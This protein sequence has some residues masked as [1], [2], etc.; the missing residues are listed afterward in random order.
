GGCLLL[1]D[2]QHRPSPPRPTRRSGGC[3][4]LIL[5]ER[6]VTT[7]PLT[8]LAAFEVRGDR[9]DHETRRGIAIGGFAVQHRLRVGAQNRLVIVARW[10]A[11]RGMRRRDV[12][13]VAKLTAR[14]SSTRSTTL[15]NL[16]GL[17]NHA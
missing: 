6:A 2:R 13:H 3:G 10:C 16:P 12:G 11:A 8:A 5:D 17:A 1:H 7:A 14:Q 15:P 4:G 9:E